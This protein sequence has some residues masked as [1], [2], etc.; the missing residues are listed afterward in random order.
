MSDKKKD[1]RVNISKNIM[2][3][4]YFELMVES[5]VG[6]ESFCHT[7]ECSPELAILTA[8]TA[9]LFGLGIRDRFL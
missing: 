6:S 7:D 8:H 1:R 9:L 5:G 3:Y 2:F 4:F